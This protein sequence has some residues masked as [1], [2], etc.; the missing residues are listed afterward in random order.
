MA[1]LGVCISFPKMQGLSRQ[2]LSLI[3]SLVPVYP[4]NEICLLFNAPLSLISQ[5]REMGGQGSLTSLPLGQSGAA[6]S[7]RDPAPPRPGHR[8]PKCSPPQGRG[9]PL[10]ACFSRHYALPLLVSGRAM[11]PCCH[12][13]SAEPGYAK[14]L[15][16]SA[17][18]VADCCGLGGREAQG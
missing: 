8:S 15:K 9:G 7:R 3:S 5:S 16:V 4:E 6:H 18:Q 13:D 1:Y 11:L 10:A 12:Q 14:T 17:I 2:F